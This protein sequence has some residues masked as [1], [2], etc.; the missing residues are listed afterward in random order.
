MKNVSLLHL[1]LTSAQAYEA[2]SHIAT[3]EIT[4]TV[5]KVL[6]QTL[7]QDSDSLIILLKS[8]QKNPSRTKKPTQVHVSTDAQKA[9][10]K[11]LGSPFVQLR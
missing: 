11:V 7:F 9:L 1:A 5:Q 6:Q 2:W 4:A 8:V 10:T 3:C